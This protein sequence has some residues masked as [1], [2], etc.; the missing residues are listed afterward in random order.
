MYA[1][2][3]HGGKQYK[4]QK[5][6]RISVEGLGA[7]KEGATVEIK[8]A[9]LVKEGNTVHVGTPYVKGASVSCRVLRIFRGDKVIAFFY[10]KRKGKKRKIGSRRHLAEVEVQEINAGK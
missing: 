5:G 1:V 3:E 6:D 4:V 7:S 10:K 9:L 8:K 2:I